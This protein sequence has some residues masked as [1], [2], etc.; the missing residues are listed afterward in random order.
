M[1]FKFSYSLQDFDGLLILPTS[2][3]EI[4][5]IHKGGKIA[6]F[7]NKYLFFLYCL[8]F[9]YYDLFLLACNKTEKKEEFSAL[10]IRES[11]SLSTI[12]S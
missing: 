2:P 4:N 11:L 1:L 9:F 7:T 3:I 10:D 5:F 6:D 12:S 8:F